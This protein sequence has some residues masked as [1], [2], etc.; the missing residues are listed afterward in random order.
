MTEPLA[1]QTTLVD[2]VTKYTINYPLTDDDGQPILDRNKKPRVTN[3]V[4]DSP[5]ELVAKI[6]SSNLELA[7]TLERSNKRFETINNRRPTPRVAAAEIAAKPLT[8]DERMQ[9]GIDAQDPRKAA[10]AI[11]RVIESTVPVREITAEVER[12]GKTVDRNERIR[13][14]RE[15]VGKNRETYLAVDA[16]NAMLNQYL[17]Q[18]GLEF[19]VE[20]LEYAAGILADRLVEP[21]RRA[22]PAPQNAAQPSPDNA[23][24]ENEAPNPGLPPAPQRR[25]PTSGLRNSQVSDRPAGDGST[26]TRTQALDMLYNDRDKY[27]AWLKDPVKAAILTRALQGR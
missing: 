20:N 13:I 19:T 22:T 7:R 1:M 11:Q 23:S 9:V 26:L 15:F 12:Q 17:A 27:E 25:A 3:L 5:E 8:P 24:P 4:A 18:K 16:N 6:A 10:D 14:S 21:P 2:G